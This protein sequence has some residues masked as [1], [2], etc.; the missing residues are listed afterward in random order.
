MSGP[1]LYNVVKDDCSRS[2]MYRDLSLLPE[3]LQVARSEGRWRYFGPKIDLTALPF[4][5]D[6]LIYLDMAEKLALAQDAHWIAKPLADLKDILLGQLT[7]TGRAYYQEILATS[8]AVAFEPQPGPGS[9]DIMEHLIS[10]IVQEQKVG[11][12]YRSSQTTPPIRHVYHPY[13][14]IVARNRTQ[15]IGWTETEQEIRRMVPVRISKL[16]ILEDTFVRRPDFDIRRAALFGYGGFG[17]PEH[18]VEIHFAPSVAHVPR[19]RP[20]NVT[21]TLI[22]KKDG[23]VRLRLRIGGLPNLATYILGFGGEAWALK[24]PALVAEIRRRARGALRTHPARR[25]RRG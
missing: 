3:P 14:L 21:Q 2:M 22:A 15:V 13:G 20:L 10:A 8:M 25:A 24:P 19:E 16:D 9:E 12:V 5:A 17:G 7:P 4:Q 6:H 23:S 18:D 1:E 11:L